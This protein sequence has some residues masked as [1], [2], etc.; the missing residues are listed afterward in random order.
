[1]N[2]LIKAPKAYMNFLEFLLPCYLPKILEVLVKAFS[3]YLTFFNKDEYY[4]LILI[5]SEGLD[6]NILC[7]KKPK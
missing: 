1:M 3:V 4:L 2:Q 7:N 5:A 6:G